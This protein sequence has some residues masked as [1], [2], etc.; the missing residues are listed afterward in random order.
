MSRY[1]PTA[2]CQWPKLNIPDM[3]TDNHWGTTGVSISSW[4]VWQ[5][6]G[7]SDLWQASW[8]TSDHITADPVIQS[9]GLIWGRG[10]SK[11][12]RLGIRAR[13]RKGPAAKR[14][15]V[16][17]SPQSRGQ[18]KTTWLQDDQHELLFGAF[19]RRS[20]IGLKA[21]VWNFWRIS[22]SEMMTNCQ[23]F[24]TSMARCRKVYHLHPSFLIETFGARMRFLAAETMMSRA[25]PL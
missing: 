11:I 3:G 2:C 13:V 17:D 4:S 16:Y 15:L 25:F 18:T 6:G 1:P 5:M 12:S 10:C 8:D 22:K 14:R 21:R 23:I 7:I 20:Q 24:C 9:W 19:E